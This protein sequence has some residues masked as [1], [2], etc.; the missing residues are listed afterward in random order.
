MNQENVIARVEALVGS[1]TPDPQRARR[2]ELREKLLAVADERREL[3]LRVAENRVEMH[4][5]LREAREA[6]WGVTNL[7]RF[8]GL[9]RRAIYN[10]LEG[11]DE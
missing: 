5:L 1:G 11:G 6:G 4:T 7:E 10:V 3:L 2:G 8:T 9:T